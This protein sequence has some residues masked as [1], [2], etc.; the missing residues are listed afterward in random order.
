MRSTNLLTYL[1]TYIVNSPSFQRNMIHR[2]GTHH[3]QSYWV[4]K[5][6]LLITE[7]PATNK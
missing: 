1:L 6:Q 3:S 4:S 5:H 7:Q 2:Q